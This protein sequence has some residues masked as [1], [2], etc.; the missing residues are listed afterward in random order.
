MFSWPERL[1]LYAHEQNFRRRLKNQQHFQD[2]Y[3]ISVGNLST[4]G[5]GKTPLCALLAEYLAKHNR[6]SLIVLR[7]YKAQL[8]KKGALVSNRVGQISKE[9][10]PN[11]NVS[12]VGDESLLLASL[13][14]TK[15]AIGKNR[16][17]VI[18]SYGEDTKSIILDDAF[19]N[20]SVHR[21]HDLV[22]IDATF[23]LTQKNM[24]LI[25][26][27][28]MREPLTALRRADTVLLTRCDQVGQ[29]QLEDLRQAIL[30][31]CPSQAIFMARHNIV[32]LRPASLT[33]ENKTKDR[34]I[35]VS[36][37]PHS[38]EAIGSFCG[39]GN[40]QAFFVSIEQLG[41]T[42]KEKRTF[43][44]HHNFRLKDLEGLAKTGLSTWI[45][46]SKDMVRIEHSNSED[47]R[48]NILNLGLNIF[49]LEIAIEI[50]QA[51]QDTF[52]ERVC[53]EQSDFFKKKI[54]LQ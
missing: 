20:P 1:Y 8:S 52:L 3:V 39:L 23:G 10:T 41:Y 31:V 22:L 11:Y 54:S 40:P 47:L 34:L 27:G 29:K 50:M 32:G 44:D 19:Q 24:R 9:N 51:K 49:V 36:A 14:N 2:K 38:Q 18:Q 21:D 30:K 25:P 13:K 53:G 16:S 7:G 35:P 4:G 26:H 17:Q 6:K 42:L 28:H 45:T 15:V 5:V 43:V 37:L 33:I 46:S 48:Q 12:Q